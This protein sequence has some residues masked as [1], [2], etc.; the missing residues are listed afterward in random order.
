MRRIGRLRSDASPSNVSDDSMAADD[1]HHQ[2]RARAGVAE[3]EVVGRREERAEPG[4]R[5]LPAAFA[6]ALDMGAQGLAGLAGAQHVV[7]FQQPFD[8]GHAAAEQAENEGA[9]R[10]RLVAGRARAPFERAASLRA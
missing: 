6:E 7:A 5:D 1:A 8:R 10:D 3:I 9:M 4:A 2:A